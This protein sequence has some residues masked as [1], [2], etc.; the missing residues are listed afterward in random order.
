VVLEALGT[1]SAIECIFGMG[2]T[3]DQVKP[4]ILSVVEKFGP[5]RCM[6][7]SH[8]PIDV[9]SHGFDRLY[10]AYENVLAEFA[11]NERDDM[12]RNTAL[13]WFRVPQRRERKS[14]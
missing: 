1:R 8:L 13:N 14:R 5:R 7:T 11:D 2:W 10:D 3:E 4:W 9:L 6:L 12:F